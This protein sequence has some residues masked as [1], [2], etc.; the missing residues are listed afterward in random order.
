[1]SKNKKIL[2]ELLRGGASQSSIA[3]ALHVSKRDVSAAAKAIAEFGLRF[4]DVMS[5]DAAAI[6]DAFFPK[7]PRAKNDS[8]LQPDMASL[9]ERKKKNR[10]LPL[11]LMWMEYCEAAESCCKLAYS[12]QAFCEM[13]AEEAKRTGAARHFNHVPGEKAYIDWAGDT[14]KITDRITGKHSKVYVLVV[15]LPHSDR[16]WAGGFA[17]MKQASW[18][19]GQMEAFEEFG[20]TPR[21]LI[22]DNCGTATDRG[23]VYETLINKDYQRFAEHYGTAVLPARVRAPRDKNLAE[24]TV[25]LVEEWVIA[26]SNELTFYTLEEFNEYCAER[27]AWLNSR[28]FSDKDGSRMSVFEE[29][30]SIELIPLP[31]E[32][33]ELCE[34]RRCKVAPNYHVRID[35]MHY[36]VP[37]D[38]IGKTV[39]VRVSSTAV[40]I[41]DAGEKV[42]EHPKLSG[43]KNQYSTIVEH[44]PDNHRLQE[45]PWSPQR[46]TSWAD[47]VGPETRAVI[48]KVLGSKAIVE[49]SFVPCLNILGLAKQYGPKMLERACA[50]ANE[51]GAVPSYTGLKNMVLALKEADRRAASASVVAAQPGS[52]GIVDNAK[53]AGRLRGADAYKRVKNSEDR[54]GGDR[55]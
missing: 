28:P 46:F 2:L 51:V 26:P 47:K 36:S 45:S 18:H 50:R 4:S 8:Y 30:E 34:W 11:K 19:D 23:S 55:C 53:S 1:M 7:A 12:Y 24:S 25:N 54:G 9:I 29:S 48:D 3:A 6:D 40:A 43:R 44:M 42:A 21:M 32:R 27:V 14:A 38:L 52:S 31:A 49:Q 16:F 37:C 22:P 20:G 15:A 39:D 13:F 5:M 41:F 17:N 33:Y 10:K 35:Y